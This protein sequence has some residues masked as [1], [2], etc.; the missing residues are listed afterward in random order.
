MTLMTS[1]DL[2][3]EADGLV[4]ALRRRPAPS[5]ASTSRVPRGARLRRARP[6][7]RRQD[8]DD[9]DARHAA[10][11]RRRRRARCSATTSCARPTRC[12]RRVSLTGQFA[13]VDED[14]TGRENLVLLGRLLG[15]AAPAR[16]A[17]ARRA[18]RRVRARRR[19]R[20]PGQDLL[21]RH[22][23][24]ARHRRQH[25]RHARAAVPRRADHRARP[26]QPQP[27]LGHRPRAG[28]RRAPPCCS[29]PVPRRGRPARRPDRGHRPRQGDRRGH[30]RRA[31]GVGRR[32]RR[33]TCAL[34]D[35]AQ[36]HGGRATVLA[37]ALGARST[38]ESDPAAL[39]R[40][41]RRRRAR[42]GRRSPSSTR[43]GDRASA[44]L[45]ARPAQPRRGVPRPD[46]PR[47]RGRPR[48]TTDAAG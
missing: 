13:S 27:G 42:R 17:R 22:A 7:R 14:L 16:E 44:E 19:R 36:R 9:P 47:R 3:I 48:P 8:D 11:A 35:P 34:H 4:K 31:E 21:G 25:R 24:P 2:A 6:E 10:A 18:A 15:F 37:R 45:L 20:P 38:L 29:H 43:A 26:A 30:A 46:R 41:R 39:S 1:T 32:R 33:C 12:A 28:R 40:P 23:P 5:T